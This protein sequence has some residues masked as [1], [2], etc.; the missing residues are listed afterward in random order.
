M[1]LEELIAQ[2]NDAVNKIQELSITKERLYGAISI[3]Q[4]QAAAAAQEEEVK[5]ETEA[6]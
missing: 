6:E 3:L 4:E 5:E 1:K 2:Y